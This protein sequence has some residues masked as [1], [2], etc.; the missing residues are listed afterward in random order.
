MTQLLGGLC[1]LYLLYC[2]LLFLLQRLMLYP[3]YAVQPFYH[4]ASDRPE[5]EKNWLQTPSG[6]VECWFI[7]PEPA[8]DSRPAPAI[9]YAHGNAELIDYWPG[10]FGEVAAAGIGVLLVE[11]PGYGRSRGKPSQKSITHA[12]TAA[13]DHLVGRPVVDSGRIVLFGASLGGGAV[14]ALAG[15]RPAAALVLMSTFTSVRDMAR[16]YLAPSFLVLDPFE[17]LAAVRSYPGPVLVIHGRHDELIPYRHGLRLHQ[18]ARKGRLITYDS[19]HNDC[20]PDWGKLIGEILTFL[21]GAGVLGC[22][23]SSGAEGSREGFVKEAS[24]NGSSPAGG[25]I[26][27][28]KALKGKGRSFSFRV[29]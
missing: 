28:G 22:P 3:R 16:K 21:R 15:R 9:V 5:I 27:P 29:T 8:D 12:F 14:C 10:A 11:Y 4:P 24:Q 19:G 20:P 17:N 26:P 13:Y 23:E 25:S 2:G 1:L 18:A 6:D 7:P